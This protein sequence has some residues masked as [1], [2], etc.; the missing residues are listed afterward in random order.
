MIRSTLLLSFCIFISACQT[1]SSNSFL[2]TGSFKPANNTKSNLLVKEWV[3]SVSESDGNTVVY[4]PS[5]HQFKEEVK[6][7]YSHSKLTFAD[8]GTFSV[9]LYLPYGSLKKILPPAYS[10]EW[11]MTNDNRLL[12]KLVKERLSNGELLKTEI[13]DYEI[14]LAYLQDEQLS[15]LMDDQSK[16][17]LGSIFHNK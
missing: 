9:K 10:G 6:T 8:D 17:F 13:E 1:N 5:T 4:R 3:K 11:Q 14:Q 12:I 15:M 16:A 7:H 2:Q